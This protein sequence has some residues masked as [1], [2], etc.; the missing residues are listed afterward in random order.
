MGNMVPIKIFKEFLNEVF[1]GDSFFKKIFWVYFFVFLIAPL[2]Y[3]IRLLY[4]RTLDLAEFGLI[5]AILS[6]LGFVSVFNNLG[7]VTILN[8]LYSKI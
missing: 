7:Y 5:Y 3:L 2:G 6:F 8:L 4:S 1:S